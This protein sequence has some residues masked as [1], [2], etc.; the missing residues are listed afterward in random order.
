LGVNRGAYLRPNE[1][2]ALELLVVELIE[3]DEPEAVLAVMTR[4]A[5]RMAFRAMRADARDEALR[6]QQMV[7]AL[8][9]KERSTRRSRR[10][11]QQY[12]D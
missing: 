12:D 1:K 7:D 3:A 5:E 8:A 6:W 11:Q 2:S 10:H 4:I 9:F